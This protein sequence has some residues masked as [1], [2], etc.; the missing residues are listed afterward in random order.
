MS[1]RQHAEWRPG[2]GAAGVVGERGG[3]ALTSSRISPACS[4]GTETAARPRPL[5]LTQARIGDTLHDGNSTQ[6]AIVNAFTTVNPETGATGRVVDYQVVRMLS[7]VAGEA[8]HFTDSAPQRRVPRSPRQSSAPPCGCVRGRGAPARQLR[9]QPDPTRVRGYSSLDTGGLRRR[10]EPQPDHLRRQRHD[11]VARLRA[12]GGAQ[13]PEG[14]R[15]HRPSR[16][17]RRSPRPPDWSC[18]GAR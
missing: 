4:Q 9:R 16:T 13:H 10:R 18:S 6:V 15:G 7:A 11:A 14:A 3:V 17:A 2:P 8:S 5:R 1:H 12:H